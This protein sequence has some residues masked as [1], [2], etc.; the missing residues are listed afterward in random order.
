[1]TDL[2]PIAQAIIIENTP[3][4]PRFMRIR[5]VKVIVDKKEVL[6]DMIYYVQYIYIN[7]Q[8]KK[9]D[10]YPFVIRSD[11]YKIMNNNEIALRRYANWEDFLERSKRE[12]SPEEFFIKYTGLTEKMFEMAKDYNLNIPFVLDLESEGLKWEV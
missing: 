1:M 11:I 12:G 9:K 4:K 2:S 10:K 7:C 6:T 3:L 5:H 8:R